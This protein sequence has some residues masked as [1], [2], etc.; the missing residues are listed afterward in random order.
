[1][2]TTLVLY[3]L[4]AFSPLAY[5]DQLAANVSRTTAQVAERRCAFLGRN[6][7]FHLIGDSGTAA[8]QLGRDQ[9][10]A[11]LVSVGQDANYWL[12]R[13]VANGDP[14]TVMWAFARRPICGRYGVL[15]YSN[16]TW[17]RFEATNAWGIGLGEELAGAASG[18]AIRDLQIDVR[19]LK[20]RV[21]K[22][23][24]NGQ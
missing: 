20:E 6:G 7:S 22:L 2:R 8:Y 3:V 12:Y 10:I 11:D 17:R 4:C 23:E 13:P 9:Y 19:D 5:A 15:R 1:M 18:D 14:S 21:L 16:G 24:R